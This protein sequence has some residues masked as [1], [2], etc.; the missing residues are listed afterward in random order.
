[1]ITCETCGGVIACPCEQQ[2]DLRIEDRTCA[3]RDTFPRSFLNNGGVK[4]V[5]SQTC[6][7]GGAMHQFVA[8]SGFVKVQWGGYT[9]FVRS[10]DQ[11]STLEH[12]KSLVDEAGRLR[13]H[14]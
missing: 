5:C 4:H 9:Y 6:D 12:L 7:V 14:P 1:M 13:E 3:L 2:Q 10:E 11:E 8:T